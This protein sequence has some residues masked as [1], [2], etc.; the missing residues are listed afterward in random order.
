MSFHCHCHWFNAI[1]L[2]HFLTFIWETSIF[3][4]WQ[5]WKI[6]TL[7]NAQLSWDISI[8]WTLRI[9]D[10]CERQYRR[11]QM[12]EM[13]AE[14]KEIVFWIELKSGTYDETVVSYDSTYNRCALLVHT[15]PRIGRGEHGYLTPA[16][17]RLAINWKLLAE[18]E[19]VLV[20][21]V[22]PGKSTAPQWKVI[23]LRS[24][25]QHELISMDFSKNALIS[26]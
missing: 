4:R 14:Y 21:N 13:G 7:W 23:H 10:H 26:V 12:Q 25:N 11:M 3:S 18:G 16:E 9:R 2:I 22:D 17:K 8:S 15:K 6:R 24:Q 19:S 1:I 20:K 5:M